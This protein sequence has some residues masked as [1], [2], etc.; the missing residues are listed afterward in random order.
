M[1]SIHARPGRGAAAG[2]GAAGRGRPARALAG[3]HRPGELR[4][5]GGG[6]GSAEPVGAAA[7]QA[8]GRGLG[9]SE[10]GSEELRK[11]RSSFRGTLER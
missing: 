4:D 3:A 11:E 9:E 7:R 2:A 1:P 5:G 10:V 8:G 6:G